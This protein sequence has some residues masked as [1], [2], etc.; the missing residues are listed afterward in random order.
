MNS[1]LIISLIILVVIIVGIFLYINTKSNDN[2]IPPLEGFTDR[3][4]TFE[5]ISKEYV[6]SHDDSEDYVIK[7]TSEWSNLWDIV[8]STVTPKPD[9][10]IIEF[11]D[12]MIIAVFMGYRSS[13]GYSIEITKIVEK[14]NSIE[15]FV[16]ETSPLP[17]SNVT[18]GIEHPHHI[19]KTEKVDKEV[20]FKR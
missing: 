20:I 10:P 12:E 6:S 18:D 11:N 7:E 9:L 15:I 14:E 3:E 5:T 2:I 8:Y 16:T 17:G 1:K 13:G 19:V 4:L